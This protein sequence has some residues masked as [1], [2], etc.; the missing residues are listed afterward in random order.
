[1]FTNF[2]ILPVPGG[3]SCV[4]YWAFI[5]FHVL[6]CFRNIKAIYSTVIIPNSEKTPRGCNLCH[7][8]N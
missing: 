6:Q 3:D 8:P 5:I 7:I 4:G 1:M 2:K